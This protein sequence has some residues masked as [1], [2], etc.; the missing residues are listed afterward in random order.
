MVV[1][2]VG[3]I[4]PELGQPAQTVVLAVAVAAAYLLLGT[5]VLGILL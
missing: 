5:G 1:V 4:T 2:E 3:L